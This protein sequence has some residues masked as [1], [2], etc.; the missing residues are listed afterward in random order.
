[1]LIYKKIIFN[2]YIYMAESKKNILTKIL[3]VY[4]ELYDSIDEFINK[5]DGVTDD[6]IYNNILTQCFTS[7]QKTLR[8]RYEDGT[9]VINPVVTDYSYFY[10]NLWFNQIKEIN[11]GQKIY[12]SRIISKYENS[13][14]KEQINSYNDITKYTWRIANLNYIIFT[15]FAV[16]YDPS[17]INTVRTTLLPN[18]KTHLTIILKKINYNISDFTRIYL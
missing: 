14:I 1:M 16:E 12:V 3:S 8:T 2:L 4:Q 6:S 11:N 13:D 7:L 18:I 17:F 9:L 5:L 10:S 15:P